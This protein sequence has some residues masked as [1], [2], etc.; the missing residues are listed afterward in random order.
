MSKKIFKYGRQALWLIHR[1]YLFEKSQLRYLFWECTLNCNFQCKHCGSHAGMNNI[2]DAISTDEIKK[3][4]LDVSNNFDAK[5]ITIAVT[6]GEPLL[7][8]DLFEV[9]EYT[10]SLGFRWGMVTNG[11]LVS[12][13][14]VQKAKKAGMRTIDISIDGIGKTHDEF[15]NKEG[16]YDKAMNAFQLFFEEDF[17]DPLRITTT[18][19]KNNIEQL[20]E[21][22]D[23]FLN[24]GVKDWRLINVDPIGRASHNSDIL[25]SP[26][27]FGQLLVFIK[28]KRKTKF[29]IRTTF[30][31]AHF[32]GDN[33]ENEVRS[34]FFFCRT[35]INIGSILHNGDIFVCP[36][37]PRKKH[38]IQ[39]NI[40]NDL[41]SEVWKNKFEIFRKK[42]RII[43]DK[44][45]KCYSWEKCL[46]GS[47][48]SWYFEKKAPK[49]C[50]LDENLYLS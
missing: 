20:D 4:F 16:S 24:L 17:L 27:E 46:G 6:G 13:E 30:G 38:L 31:C 11:Y 32:L 5:N 8:K 3:A 39:G 45:K 28:E 18:V 48:H 35:G 22:Y 2:E 47:F 21:M 14:I 41:F 19:H 10:S 37:V 9:M 1:D 36:N 49:I 42:D 50:F 33:Y 23:A 25:L 34:Y 15:R 44:C 40:G 26:E 29:E 12:K 43:C 7:R